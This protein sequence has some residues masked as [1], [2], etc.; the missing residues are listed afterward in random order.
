MLGLAPS[1]KETNM[2]KTKPDAPP[3]APDDQTKPDA[4]PAAPAPA[5]RL[6]KMI[7][8]GGNPATADVHPDEVANYAAGGWQKETK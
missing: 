1:I 8:P 5:L 6:V 4:P 7:R 2:A 3:A